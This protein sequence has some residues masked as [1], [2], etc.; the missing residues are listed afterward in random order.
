MKTRVL[1]LLLSGA[2]C[3]VVALSQGRQEKPAI[4]SAAPSPAL[5]DAMSSHGI[6]TV[7]DADAAAGAPALQPAVYHSDPN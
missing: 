1:L 7:T 5:L 4:A 3:A 6:A 2:T